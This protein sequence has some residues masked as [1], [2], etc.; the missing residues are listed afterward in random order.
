MWGRLS[1][2]RIGSVI[3]TR[4]TFKHR[5]APEDIHMI[6]LRNFWS[7]YGEDTLLVSATM[8]V[9]LGLYL[10]VAYLFITML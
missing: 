7:N 3:L 6:R 8:I 5:P 4:R 1:L 9:S 2:Q 10:L